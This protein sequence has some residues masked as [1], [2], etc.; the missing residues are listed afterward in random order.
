M[1]FTIG[2]QQKL[3]SDILFQENANAMLEIAQRRYRWQF[4]AK[5]YE[6]LY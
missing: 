1:W 4:I 5:Q 3:N 2:K 6:D